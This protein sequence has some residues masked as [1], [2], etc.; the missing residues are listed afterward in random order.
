MIDER[1]YEWREVHP[2][3]HHILPEKLFWLKK[4]NGAWGS[5]EPDIEDYYHH[6]PMFD[7]LRDYKS[8]FRHINKF[9]TVIQAGGNCGMYASFYCKFFQ[10]VISFEANPYTFHALKKNVEPFNCKCY[11]CA[12]SDN[13]IKLN[14]DIKHKTNTGAHYIT[15]EELQEYIIEV[16]SMKIDDLNLSELDLIHLDL[17]NHE[18]NAIKGAYNSIEK[19]KPI[20]ISEMEILDE[21]SLIGSGY[22]LYGNREDYLKRKERRDFIYLPL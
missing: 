20:I 8:W 9:G 2:N 13:T 12:L 19:F 14:L 21:L 10:N 3:L 18:I 15:D 7:L 17:E 1:N 6:G 5:Y 16:S 22:K 11:N 4:D